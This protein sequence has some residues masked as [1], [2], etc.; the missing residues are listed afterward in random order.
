MRVE[1][2]LKLGFKDVLIRPKRSTL[3][4]R[5]QVELER[6]FTF[7]HSRG[8]GPACRS[9]PPTWIPSAPSR[10]PR[11]WPR[12][13]VLCG[14]PQTLLPRANGMLSR[15]ARTG[16][17]TRGSWSAPASLDED[18][19]KTDARY[20]SRHPDWNL[21]ASTSP[22][23][24]AE[25]FVEFVARVRG[26]LPGQDHRRRQRGHRRDGRGAASVRAPISS[27]SASGP[28]RSARPGVKTGVG[29]PQLSA[30]DRMRRRRPRP[31]GA[32]H[33]RRRLKLRRATW[34]RPSAAAPTSSCWAGCSP[35]T[36][37]AAASW[38][39]ATGRSSSCFTA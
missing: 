8:S 28:V 6:T 22:T 13:T 20:S 29:Y 33:L 27:R 19:D 7:L 16:R 34:P 25:S 1:T 37:K 26:D 23:A 17:S 3:K 5:A 38:S 18:F 4:S 12:T 2:D 10:S 30:D 15:P 36:M 14:R 35:A 9:S 32:D 24:T 31:G 21:S 11:F 39:S